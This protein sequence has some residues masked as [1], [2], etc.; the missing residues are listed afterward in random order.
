MEI[1]LEFINENYFWIIL[2]AV[3]LLMSLIGYITEQQGINKSEKVVKNKKP[4]KEKKAKQIKE[5][6][7]DVPN[8]ETIEP[9]TEQEVD[10]ISEPREEQIEEIATEPIL[11]EQVQE[12]IVPEI[13]EE[14]FAPIEEQKINRENDLNIDKDFN[15]VLEDVEETADEADIELPKLDSVSS[16]ELDDE[17]DIW[18]F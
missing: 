14:L 9:V 5:T 18:K 17:E 13:D 6:V 2:I 3:I 4:K 7:E 11:T 16:D 15:H 8:V 12:E 10:S 1:I